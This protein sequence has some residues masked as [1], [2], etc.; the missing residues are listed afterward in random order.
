MLATRFDQL[1]GLG[2]REQQRT[3]RRGVSG[4]RAGWTGR[5][6]ATPGITRRAPAFQATALQDGLWRL[7]RMNDIDVGE[8]ARLDQDGFFDDRNRWTRSNTAEFGWILSFFLRD[9]P[10]FSRRQNNLKRSI[11]VAY[12]VL[13][14]AEFGGLTID[15]NDREFHAQY[16]LR[17]YTIFRATP[18]DDNRPTSQTG[19]FLRGT[20]RLR[21]R[22]RNSF[23]ATA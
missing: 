9:D 1:L 5:N 6:R 19:I 8:Y 17:R 11:L 3:P 20:A 13:R 23:S 15:R 4:E 18:H 14:G 2:D 21:E 10:I 16:A 22:R 7:T 12:Y